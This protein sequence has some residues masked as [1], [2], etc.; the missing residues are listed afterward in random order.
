MIIKKLQLT[1][2]RKFSSKQF[3]FSPNTTVII[4]ANATGKT[5]LAESLFLIS[6]GKSFRTSTDA[7]MILFDKEIAR[8]SSTVEKENQKETQ[9]E[10]VLTYGT[11]MNIKTPIKRFLVNGIGKRSIDFIGNMKIVLFWPQDMELVTYSPSLRRR[12]IDFVLCQVDREYRR[13]LISYEKGLRQRNK[14][15]EAIR[16][17]AAH[18]H[19][20]LFW[21]QLLIKDGV[22]IFSK[23]K[24][25]IDYINSFKLL[26]DDSHFTE[27][28]LYYDASIIS[29]LRLD[30][31]SRQEIAA[32]VT[33]VGPH[34]DDF[35][36]EIRSPIRQLTDKTTRNLSHFGSRGEQRLAILWLKMAELS[37]IEKATGEKPILLLD[38]I[39]SE[40]DHH[41]RDIVLDVIGEQQSIVTITEKEQID[42]K[43]IKEV[44]V[45]E[46]E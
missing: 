32:G 43:R 16:D 23:R 41:H 31:Y 10:I 3:L 40:L 2:F 44:E 36:F 17:R 11:V 14:V 25:Y 35:K 37:Y 22:Y 34:R 28:V 38:D 15:L 19:Q 39:F 12:Y 7:E 46:L 30:Q 27:H 42:M 20:L 1:N 18:Q 8:I 4:G 13:S 6:T 24:Q 26:T 5:N 9:L 29:R 33:L 21:D 45:I